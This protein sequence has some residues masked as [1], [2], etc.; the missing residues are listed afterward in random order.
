M[1]KSMNA[2]AG[3][4]ASDTSPTAVTVADLGCPGSRRAISPTCWPASR[5]AIIRPWT[6]TDVEP[7]SRKQTSL[8]ESPYSMMMDP[9]SHP[10]ISERSHSF[11][12]SWR[13][14]PTTGC[15][16]KASIAKRR[17]SVPENLYSMDLNHGGWIGRPRLL[18]R[19]PGNNRTQ[20]AF[21]EQSCAYN[22]APTRCANRHPSPRT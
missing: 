21:H 17:P 12:A 16:T 5:T 19:A 13:S 18:H 9:D 10:S 11:A 22:Q 7:E 2:A 3:V 8:A 4:R 1:A 14:P 6:A 15:A 20:L